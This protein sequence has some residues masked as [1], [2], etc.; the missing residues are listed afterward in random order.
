[1]GGLVVIDFIDM[2]SSKN[3]R[4]V[5]NRVR[6]ALEMDRARVQ[7]GRIS[8]FG[9]LEMSRQRLRPSLGE[10]SGVVCPRCN[11]LGF[12]RDIESLGLSI[13]RLMEEEALK[14][15]SAQIRAIVPLS[16]AAYL[17]NEKRSVLTEIEQR[18]QVKLMIVPSAEMDTPHYQVDRIR[19]QD[20]DENPEA[21]YE[22][23][24]DPIAEPEPAMAPKSAQAQQAVVRSITPTAPPPASQS[25]IV[26]AVAE[27]GLFSRLLGGLFGAGKSTA[28]AEK[29]ATTPGA[30]TQPAKNATGSTKPKRR[31]RNE[32]RNRNRDTEKT[33]STRTEQRKPARQSDGQRKPAQRKDS[34]RKGAAK[35][36]A[37]DKDTAMEESA[38]SA[39][40]EKQ[41]ASTGD[42]KTPAKPRQRSRRASPNAKPETTSGE[43][44]NAEEDTRKTDKRSQGN[45]QRTQKKRRSAET[46]V[47]SE[48]GT[49]DPVVAAAETAGKPEESAAESHGS[50]RQL[51]LGDDVMTKDA[52][53]V[54]AN[55]VSDD[56][57]GSSSAETRASNDPRNR[58]ADAPSPAI[59]AKADNPRQE[60]TQPADEKIER[61]TGSR[62][63]RA[64]EPDEHDS[65]SVTT[66]A[67]EL[68]PGRSA[69]A[70]ASEEAEVPDAISAQQGKSEK[71]PITSPVD[72]DASDAA[73]GQPDTDSP[74]P[75]AVRGR[76]PNDPRL[77]RANSDKQTT[78][79]K[80]A[81]VTSFGLTQAAGNDTEPREN[82]REPDSRD[83]ESSMNQPEPDPS[84]TEAPDES[85][86]DLL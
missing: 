46:T 16:V 15:S 28:D 13:M 82:T 3:Q 6:K 44:A 37:P 74:K 67:I 14:E 47:E 36:E 56:L 48:A 52:K 24:A 64:A 8:R 33:S 2:S 55:A 85:K 57:P 41:A 22:I 11:G 80:T 49:L 31:S 29:V 66:G 50:S 12:I 5:E 4:T 19:T 18:H 34:T 27:K 59:E 54:G 20:E 45:R 30:T 53:E 62:E 83:E 7:V 61:D 17:L 58:N 9:L 65:S 25:N 1:M 77:K 81:D 63:R 35:S 84:P 73:T 21:S 51:E 68:I 71:K 32:S 75:A 78:V 40:M 39:D 79:P 86:Q 38:S 23:V 60:S 70:P 76:A 72:Q 42:R 43:S 69:T 10:T 26:P